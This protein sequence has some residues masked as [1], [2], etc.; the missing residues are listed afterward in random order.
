M[1]LEK[2]VARI[3]QG[4]LYNDLTPELVELRKIAV[5]LTDEYNA[6]YGQAPE[7]REN[8]LRKLVKSAGEGA[9]FEPGFRCEFGR[10]ITP[11]S[12]T[13]LELRI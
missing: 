10:N 7:I 1:E 13:H 2:Q 8:I 9:F 4:K 5:I 11:V 12:Y 3:L 6:S